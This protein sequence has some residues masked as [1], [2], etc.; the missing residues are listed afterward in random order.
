VRDFI[1]QPSDSGKEI[2]LTRELPM[3]RTS[4]FLLTLLFFANVVNL[5]AQENRPEPAKKLPDGVYAVLREG[6]AEKDLLPLKDG[7]VLA[8]DRQLYAKN[9]DK[10]PPRY[11][12][13]HKAPDVLLDLVGE[14]KAVKEGDDVV[15]I[16]LKLQPKSAEELERLTKNNVGKQVAICLGGEVVSA[17]KIRDAIKGGDVQISCCAPGSAKY[18]LEQLQKQQ[19]SK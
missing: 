14:P 7:E 13:V 6:T 19:K 18:L 4:V 17:H 5:P 1:C 12:V 8:V 11:L 2:L 3:Q 16:L 10:N 9:D 15:R